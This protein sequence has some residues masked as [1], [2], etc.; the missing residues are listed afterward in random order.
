M[1]LARKL[2]AFDATL[3]VTGGIIG[4][5]IFQNPAVVAQRLHTAPLILAAWIFGGLVALIGGFIFAELAWRR[6]ASGGLYG[7]MRDG[8][9]PI[10]AFMYGWT[11]LCVSQS[12]G[13]AAAA[14]TFAAYIV[15][16]R[17]THLAP[18]IP[19]T[20][21]IVVLSAINCF[22]VREG[23]N[24]QNVLM[25]VKLG[26]IVALV[27]GGIFVSPIGHDTVWTAAVIPAVGPLAI[28][29]MFGAALVP[30]L[31]AYDGWQTAPFIDGELKDARR[32]L[33][34]GLIAGVA[35][36]I[37]LYVAVTIVCLRVLGAANLAATATPASDAM[38]AAF[39]PLGERII[40]IGVALSA[41]G[42][43]SNQVLTSPRIYY[44]MANDGVFLRSLSWVHPKTRAPV[45][46]IIVQAILAIVIAVSGRYDQILNYV[47]AMDF[48]FL[49]LAGIALFVFIRRGAAQ[50]QS[51]VRVP[52]HPWS[53]GFFVLVSAAV[54][55]NTYIT[56]PRDTLIGL[57]I[58]LSGIPIYLIWRRFG[59]RSQ[60]V[61]AN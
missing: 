53:T 50:A 31:Y 35:I 15:A 34:F 41:L 9:H 47:T 57:G 3:I 30:V 39:G 29:S 22:G 38:R 42:F 14:V 16:V 2:N 27:L 33:P 37:V 54:V 6:P 19:A 18:W 25:I 11:A 13:M 10:V 8:F 40:A 43:I 1:K 21:A 5:G 28:V 59:P 60:L 56:F 32:T 58:L 55:I 36:V 17:H 46:A 51:G 49:G 4:V 61:A 52:L 48:I 26:I 45:V 7:Y 44:A 12:G 23:G 20:A 24:A